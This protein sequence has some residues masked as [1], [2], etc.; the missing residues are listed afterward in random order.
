MERGPVASVAARRF[1]AAIAARAGRPALHGE[2]P[3][4]LDTHGAL[5]AGSLAGAL[6]PEDFFRDR[7]D[8]P[9]DLRL[10]VVLLHRP[11]NAASSSAPLAR[12]LATTHD[13]P[14]SELA[15][16]EGGDLES[17][18][19]L[20]AVTDFASVYLAITSTGRA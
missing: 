9:E 8:E 6:D 5:L 13:T 4:A 15:P 2:L 14:L 18:V 16:A 3:E 11:G 10:R 19:E 20:L 1:A 7:V 17:A 12:E